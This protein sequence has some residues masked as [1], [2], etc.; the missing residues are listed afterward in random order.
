MKHHL[1][2]SLTHH[3][4]ALFHD[5][6]DQAFESVLNTLQRTL[7]NESKMREW[8]KIAEHQK[9][10]DSINPCPDLTFRVFHFKDMKEFNRHLFPFFDKQKTVCYLD[11]LSNC[12]KPMY[13]NYSPK[14]CLGQVVAGLLT[15]NEKNAEAIRN[16][17]IGYCFNELSK[18][19]KSFNDTL[20]GY[21][22]GYNKGSEFHDFYLV[23]IHKDLYHLS[24]I[25]LSYFNDE[26]TYQLKKILSF[27]HTLY[28]QLDTMQMSLN[29]T[30]AIIKDI[31]QLANEFSWKKGKNL[32][33]PETII[34][35]HKSKKLNH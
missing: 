22:D 17:F 13:E 28:N 4:N 34:K 27:H 7:A 20:Y 14:V 25:P 9:T 6:S 23:L 33:I 19:L 3:Y 16:H 30:K 29:N 31:D 24:S 11:G 32:Y 2:Y 26:Q 8:Q 21:I 5:C 15:G 12:L 10:Y 35:Q 1:Q 18:D